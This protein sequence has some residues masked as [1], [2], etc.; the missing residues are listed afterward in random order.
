MRVA[1][2][3]QFASEWLFFNLHLRWT[4]CTVYLRIHWRL[5]TI[6]E[7]SNKSVWSYGFWYVKVCVFWNRIQYTIHWDKIQILQQF[8]SDKTNGTKTAF[9]FLSRAPTHHSFI[10]NLRFLYD[11]N[12]KVHL[13]ELCVGFVIF[14]SVSFLLKFIFSLIKMHGLFYFKTS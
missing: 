5:S 4:K 7:T 6:L 12:H 3:T 9:F 1:W 2:L 14:D 13:S 10:F 8:P 11:L